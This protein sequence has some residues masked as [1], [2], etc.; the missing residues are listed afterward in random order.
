P[1]LL[2]GL[3]LPWLLRSR[4]FPLAQQVTERGRVFGQIGLSSLGCFLV[5]HAL[6]FRLHH[7]SRYTQHSLKVV[8]ALAAG[9]AL[10]ILLDGL[11]RWSAQ[12]ARQ[13]GAIATTSILS[14]LLLI[15][16]ALIQFQAR[17]PLQEWLLPVRIYP[18]YM[19]GKFPDLY[20]FFA[21][22][23]KS[24][25]IASLISEADNLP[26]FAQRSILVGREYGIPYH[27]G[28]YRQFRERAIDLIRAQ[29]SPSLSEVQRFTDQYGIDFWLL[30][31]KTF[32]PEFILSKDWL[33]Q[34]QPTTQA[35][36]SAL[37][38][39]TKP[40]V[41]QAID[42]CTVFRSNE[43]R[44]LQATCVAAPERGS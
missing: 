10:T 30:N 25:L 28:Y 34:Y 13:I 3:L 33:Q 37:Q 41:Q 8:L 39:G 1:L 23:P 24:S 6:L 12:G 18:G 14:L 16:P 27:L 19:A 21:E 43:L 2:A 22:Q 5:A 17:S 38:Q 42:R 11:W 36:V 44:V 9:V 7:P 26:T 29:Y 20:N 4:H 15:Y 32:T 35:A 40:I 31:D